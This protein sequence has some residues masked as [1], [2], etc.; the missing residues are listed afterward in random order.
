MIF[1]RGNRLC[2]VSSNIFD[3]IYYS[4]LEYNKWKKIACVYGDNMS[5]YGVP[6]ASVIFDKN[7]K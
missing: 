6:H 4:K 7:N 3:D 5:M 2:Y 1:K